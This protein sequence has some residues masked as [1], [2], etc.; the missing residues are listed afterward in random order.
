MDNSHYRLIFDQS[1]NEIIG[2]NL[3]KL[4]KF[5]NW[6]EKCCN[7]RKVQ[8]TKFANFLYYC[9]KLLPLPK[10]VK[11]ATRNTNIL[12]ICELRKAIFS[13]FY[14][15]SRLNFGI[16]LLLVGSFREFRFCV[17]ICLDKKL[18]YNQ[19]VYCSNPLKYSIPFDSISIYH[20]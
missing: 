10:M 6:V 7:M 14:K 13:V 4:A 15:M 8:L 9:I 16:L 2:K 20:G 18:V 19:I 1:K 3:L 17:W 5:Q 12:K 11:I